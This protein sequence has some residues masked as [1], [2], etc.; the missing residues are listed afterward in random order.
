MNIKS[1]AVSL[2]AVLCAPVQADNLLDVYRQAVVNDPGFLAAD[3]R[4]QASAQGPVVAGSTFK[5]Q[6]SFSSS[7]DVQREDISNVGSDSYVSG[8]VAVSVSQTLYNRQ[9]RISI[10]QSELA[11]ERANID[12]ESAGDNLILRVATGYFAV[13]GAIDNHDLAVSEKIAIKR[14]LELAQERLNVGIGTQTDL[15]DAE[16]RYQIVEAN[17]IEAVNFIEDATQALIAIVGS[18][19]GELSKLK[20]DAPLEPPTPNQVD[21]WVN[22]AV[23][24]NPALQS[25]SLGLEIARQE[26]E[27]QRHIKSPTVSVVASQSYADANGGVTSSGNSR[28]ASSVGLRLAMPLY[29]G[30]ADKA[31]LLEAS[32]NANAQEQLLEQVR[33]QTTRNVKD[34]FNDVTSGIRQVYALQKAVVAGESA[35]EA[36][37][38]GFAAGLI[39]NL[40][41]LDAQRDLFQASRNY[42]RAR[43]D[44]I[45]AVL[46]LEQ[47]AGQ[48]DE[49]DVARVNNWLE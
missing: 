39:T 29:T 5:P 28:E 41:V 44:Y 11:N 17:E 10:K 49:E 13:L 1:L 43:Y 22:R 9:G 42:L 6:V 14:Q 33:R 26:V 36:K 8:S 23:A 18:A 21:D 7:L 25:E 27:R 31:Q 46:S 48:L 32:L 20:E 3:Y 47:A 12:F 15:Y 2:I 19:P 30:G 34:V 40:D 4:R 37:N 35:V 24:N 45:L 38:E 16:A